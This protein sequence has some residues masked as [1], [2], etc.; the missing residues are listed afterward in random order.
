M[1][2]F[3]SYSSTNS[4]I[5]A[6]ETSFGTDKPSIGISK[7][8]GMLNFDSHMLNCFF[9][10]LIISLIVSNLFEL[11]NPICSGTHL[12]DKMPKRGIVSCLKFH[13]SIRGC[14]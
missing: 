2:L 7:S 5:V 3:V 1:S 6:I 13:L 14:S 8:G 11:S 4:C 9:F 12:Y 10:Y